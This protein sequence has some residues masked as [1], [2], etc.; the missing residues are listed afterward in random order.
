VIPFRYHRAGNAVDALTLLQQPGAMALAGGTTLLDLMKLGVAS[1]IHVV[2]I[3]DLPWKDI[4]AEATM[5]RIGALCSNS[6]VAGHSVVVQQFP[7]V[8]QALLSGASG[9]IRNMAT[10]GGNLMQ[11][12]RC[13]YFRSVDYPCNKRSPG[14]GCA[15]V[16]GVHG[17]H[18]V[19]GVSDACIAVYPSDL[20]VAL[21]AVDASVVLVSNTGERTV[22][23]TEFLLQPGSTPDRETSLGHGELITAID[24][25]L[26]AAPRVSRYL[27]LRGRASFAFAAVSVA[28][29]LG[30]RGAGTDAT[31]ALGGV[32]TVP[33]RSRP[34]EQ[35]LADTE[36]SKGAL[37]AFCDTLLEGAMPT[38]SNRY[39]L[40]MARG[41]VARMFE[42][43]GGEQWLR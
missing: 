16:A 34:A 6:S 8:S 20:A 12:T 40:R 9:Q 13:P 5:L 37:E 31:V 24:I 18:A 28:A 3:Q 15:A 1:P 11:R 21:A 23:L 43:L 25:P 27:K 14:S 4:S 7:L 2:D 35:L 19:L 38:E 22:P 30:S 33:W 32:G 29:T 39:K 17:S 10:V 36:P 42:E 41:A 26:P